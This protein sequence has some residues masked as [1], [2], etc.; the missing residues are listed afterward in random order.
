VD[1]VVNI[2]ANTGG[3]SCASY[4]QTCNDLCPDDIHNGINGKLVPANIIVAVQDDVGTFSCGCCT[5]GVVSPP[6]NEEETPV[7]I[8]F[9]ALPAW[10]WALIFCTPVVLWLIGGL[11]AWRLSKRNTSNSPGKADDACDDDE[12]LDVNT[13]QF[14]FGLRFLQQV[15]LSLTRKGSLF[16]RSGVESF[17]QH[18]S[19]YLQVEMGENGT[20]E[21]RGTRVGKFLGSSA[22]IF[23]VM[24]LFSEAQRS[25]QP[26]RKGLYYGGWRARFYFNFFSVLH[27]QFLLALFISTRKEPHPAISIAMSRAISSPNPHPQPLLL[28]VASH[29]HPAQLRT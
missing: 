1:T 26:H 13:F 2:A 21:W 29:Y 18:K 5:D 11:I 23:D 15:E 7:S 27:Y 22:G 17:L 3:T 19:R 14:P 6:P 16:S 20:L 8:D 4:M 28:A 25:A 10:I 24:W 9:G 12:T